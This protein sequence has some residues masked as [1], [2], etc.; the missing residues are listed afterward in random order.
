MGR[1]GPGDGVA[2]RTAS[3]LASVPGPFDL[4]SGGNGLGSRVPLSCAFATP[5]PNNRTGHKANAAGRAKPR[6][7][8][9]IDSLNREN[10]AELI[11]VPTTPCGRACERMNAC[12]GHRW[13]ALVRVD[14]GQSRLRE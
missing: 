1:A 5:C 14:G 9:F 11:P 6:L 8:D 12:P 3:S 13:Q 7:R 4:V 10:M 2:L